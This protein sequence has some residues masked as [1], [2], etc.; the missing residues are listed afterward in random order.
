MPTVFLSITSRWLSEDVGVPITTEIVLLSS[1]TRQ[2]SLKLPKH[3][4]LLWSSIQVFFI[5]EKVKCSL[6]P[7][8]SHPGQVHKASK[9]CS[10]ILHCGQMQHHLVTQVSFFWKIPAAA[11][12]G[13]SVLL[14]ERP[15]SLVYL[16]EVI[17]FLHCPSHEGK[18]DDP[19]CN[20]SENGFPIFP[21]LKPDKDFW[22]EPEWWRSCSF[23]EKCLEFLGV[24]LY[25]I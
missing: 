13:H 17:A 7:I 3:H 11:V 9:E 8:L 10:L 16:H 4:V 21:G 24:L 5:L 25:G 20:G 19:R 1:A 14:S 2:E 15:G 6:H 18:C 22:L 23:R 12:A